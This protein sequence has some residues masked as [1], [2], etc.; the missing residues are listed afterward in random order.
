MVRVASARR[1]AELLEFG[2]ALVLTAT[3][4]ADPRLPLTKA[5]HKKGDTAQIGAMAQSMCIHSE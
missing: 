2:L 3:R 1:R 4:V 5:A